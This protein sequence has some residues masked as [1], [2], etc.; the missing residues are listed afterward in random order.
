[1]VETITLCITKMRK[2]IK[3]SMLSVLLVAIA[4][5]SLSFA[6]PNRHLPSPVPAPTSTTIHVI[7]TS[8]LDYSDS[9][10]YPD[11]EIKVTF[12]GARYSDGQELTDP[13]S[14]FYGAEY[15]FC[16]PYFNCTN[17]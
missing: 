3:F 17:F 13:S 8:A 6:V 7:Y 11:H 9:D 14:P 2:T 4:A 1:M 16:N 5:I 10:D 15:Y 12:Y